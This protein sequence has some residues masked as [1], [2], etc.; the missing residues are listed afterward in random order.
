[1]SPEEELS[2]YAETFHG[3][4]T[5][6]TVAGLDQLVYGLEARVLLTMLLCTND[7]MSDESIPRYVRA[8][9]GAAG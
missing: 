4:P 2:R 3:A 1:V 8:K 9:D 5:E 7:M 6:L